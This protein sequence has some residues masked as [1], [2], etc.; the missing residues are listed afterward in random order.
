METLRQIANDNYRTGDKSIITSMTALRGEMISNLEKQES[1]NI[2]DIQDLD[3]VGRFTVAQ[4]M[5][6]KCAS[7]ARKYLLTDEHP[8]VRSAAENA[9]NRM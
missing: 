7:E 4:S 5:F 6:S 9:K 8:H 3:R 1:I 2:E